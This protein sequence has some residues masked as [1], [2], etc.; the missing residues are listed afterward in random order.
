MLKKMTFRKMTVT[1]SALLVLSCFYFFPTKEETLLIP[2]NIIYEE[3]ENYE[4][5]FLIDKYD[6]VSLTSLVLD[7]LDSKENIKKRIEY[8]IING[9]YNNNIP[10]GFKPII[11]EGTII[12][13]I[14]LNESKA[15]IYFSKEILNIEEKN[16]SKMIEAIIY[17][18]TENNAIEE[19]Y[20]Y[21][22]EVLIEKIS[23]I[24]LKYPLTRDYGVNKK[25]DFDSLNN[26]TKTTIYYI[27][28]I[29]DN[30]YY[31]PITYVSNNTEEK[32]MIIINELKSS[33]VYQSNLLS[34]LNNNAELKKYEII[35][36]TMYLSFNDKIFDI[37]GDNK[38]LEEVKYTIASSIFENYDVNEVV[39]MLNDEEIS[40]ITD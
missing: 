17:T 8:L 39:F 36:E 2:K 23:N 30:S 37:V 6:Y 1:L 32:I 18:I 5:V 3:N 40:K 16:V 35:E 24:Y 11:P 14:K 10:N 31:V 25:Y 4:N 21:S 19:V 26:L 28:E 7:E 13:D 34:Y 27:S 38:I 12:N 33:T 20:L 15:E 29:N 9:K 22:E